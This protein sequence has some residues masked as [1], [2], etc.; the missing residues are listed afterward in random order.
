M[1][2]RDNK[3]LH[4]E[5]LGITNDFLYPSSSKIYLKEPHNEDEYD[6]PGNVVLNRAVVVDSD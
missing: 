3:S 5:V 2:P 1:E 4:N 6:R